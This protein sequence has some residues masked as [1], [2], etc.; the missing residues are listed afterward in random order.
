MSGG[1]SSKDKGTRAENRAVKE[2]NHWFEVL[3]SRL[4]AYRVAGSGAWGGLDP[5]L[6]SDAKVVLDG[7]V[8]ERIEVKHRADPPTIADMDGWRAFR[9]I[10][11]AKRLRGP[12]LASMNEDLWVKLRRRAGRS[13]QEGAIRLAGPTRGV[14][15]DRI[16]TELQGANCLLAAE[17]DGVI[18]MDMRYLA[19]LLHEAYDEAEKPME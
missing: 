11:V 9:R 8:E 14:N 12:F 16:Y 13:M 17:W 5:A 2:L 15:S 19:E 4:K 10:L 1:R 6:R 7:R 3:G 18:Y